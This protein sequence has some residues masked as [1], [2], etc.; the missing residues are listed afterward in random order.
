MASYD[1]RFA[2]VLAQK[3]REDLTK[4]H[5]DLGSGAHLI[6]EDAA[7]TGMNCA[8]SI[9]EIRGLKR[10]LARIEEVVDELAGKP[11]K[12]RQET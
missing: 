4:A 7:A 5:N 8:T 2:Q 12:E 9:G 6:R 1:A 10:A 11:R 3:L